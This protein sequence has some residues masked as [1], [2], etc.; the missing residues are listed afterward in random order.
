MKGLKKIALA[1]AVAAISAGAQAE[2]KAL[3]DSALGELTGQAGLTIDLETKYTIGEFMYKDAGSL[4]LTGLELGGNEN[5]NPGGYLDNI[6][7]YIDIAGS[8]AADSTNPFGGADNVMNY[9]FSRIA[10]LA[11]LVVGE[12]LTNGATVDPGLGAAATGTD[13]TTSLLIDTK[14]TYG[15]GD[16]VI[17]FSFNDVLEAG[18]GFDAYAGGSGTDAN[19]NAV[20]NLEDLDYATARDVGTRSVDFNFS[21]DAIGIADSTFTAGDSVNTGTNPV[22]DVY[23]KGTGDAD[24]YTTGIDSDTTTTVLISQLDINGYLGPA[25]LHI[26]NDGNGFGGDGSGVDADGD[27]NIDTGTGNADSVITWGSYFK[28]TDLDIYIDIAG[29]WLKDVRI[30]NVR[31]DL[32]G[33]DGTSAFGFAH[34]ERT[35]YAVKDAVLDIGGT[36]G[37]GLDLAGIDVDTSGTIGAGISSQY[38]DG[39]ALNTRFKGDI[40]IGAIEFGNTGTSIGSIY[41]T[42]IDS[43]TKWTISAH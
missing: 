5:V 30:E 39:L 35:I 12:Q 20:G 19:G 40:D 16:L 8:G 4:F 38:V 22:A 32:S 21:I 34:S 7:I 42:D 43:D 15:D 17:H 27:G 41:L 26:E 28:V 18:G 23:R 1:S 9:G 10:D 13:L 25:D 14:K 31:G 2:L 29:A 37:N 6:R 36:A 11:G 3:D 33:L 24:Y